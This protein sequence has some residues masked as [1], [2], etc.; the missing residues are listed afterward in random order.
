MRLKRK[1]KVALVVIALIGFLAYE[2]S[3]AYK[4]NHDQ[5]AYE[6]FRASVLNGH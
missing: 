5:K 6:Q 2:L 1:V 4:I 3:M